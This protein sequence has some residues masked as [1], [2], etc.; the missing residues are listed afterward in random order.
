VTDATAPGGPAGTSPHEDASPVTFARVFEEIAREELPSARTVRAAFDAILSG[1]WTPV[2]VAGFAVALR[3]RGES[4]AVIQAAAEALRAVMVP[5]EH[6]LERVIDTCGTG[7]DGLGTINVSTAAALVVAATGLPVA[8]HGNRSVSSRCGSADV[9][10]ALGVPLDVP[11][12]RQAEVLRRAGIAFLFAPLHHPAMRHG[13]VAR[14]ELAIRTVFNALGPVVNPAR[15]SHQLI[16]AYDDALR[17]ILAETLGAL[18]SRR[19]WIVRGED[20][21]DEISPFGPTRVTELRAPGDLRERVVRPED[22][23]VA[24]AATG[25]LAGGDR[26]DNARSLTALLQG[27]PHPARS[28][29]V[30]NAAAAIAI[31]RDVDL[32][33]G[34]AS[35]QGA[36]RAATDE[37]AR[38]IDSGAA[39]GLLE[40]W[41]EA[42]MAARAAGAEDSTR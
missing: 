18:G 17:P 14:R 7:G 23:G 30:L 8:K 20:G 27:T 19:A 28:A 13:G 21:L 4:G 33:P 41:R 5:V 32:E 36:L 24:P 34:T 9:L 25:A 31:G 22:F 6:G 3:L 42:A 37:A 26:D 2:Q 15:A 12:L 40:T 16:G 38:A 1:A 39:L 11:P 10:E 29:V 35:G